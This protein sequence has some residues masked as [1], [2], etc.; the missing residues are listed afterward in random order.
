MQLSREP[1]WL[2]LLV[3]LGHWH[4]GPEFLRIGEFTYTNAEA[5]AP[6][7]VDTRST[8]SDI[9]FLDKDQHAILRLTRSKT[10]LDYTG[11]EIILGGTLRTKLSAHSC[12]CSALCQV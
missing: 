4:S 5:Q 7:F 10:D 2:P 1:L 9:I 3:L 11:V 12:N 6:T 8:R